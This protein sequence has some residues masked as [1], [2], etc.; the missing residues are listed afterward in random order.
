MVYA[1]VPGSRRVW[2][3]LVRGEDPFVGQPGGYFRF[4]TVGTCLDDTED[5]AGSPGRGLIDSTE[6]G[7]A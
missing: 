2:R 7:T 4:R 6:N 5:L 1:G 3:A